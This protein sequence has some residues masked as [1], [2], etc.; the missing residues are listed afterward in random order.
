MGAVYSRSSGLDFW[1]QT[2]A[3]VVNCKDGSVQPSSQFLILYFRN[4]PSLAC[5]ALSDAREN[6]IPRMCVH[7]GQRSAARDAFELAKRFDLV[8]AANP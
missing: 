6:D 2:V 4:S 8:A 3:E 1:G 7:D 5:G